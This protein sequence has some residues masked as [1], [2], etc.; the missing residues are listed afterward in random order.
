MTIEVNYLGIQWT[1][2]DHLQ[3]EG[4]LHL[5]EA[6]IRKGRAIPVWSLSNTMHLELLNGHINWAT[7]IT[8]GK[9]S[10]IILG[11]EANNS[12]HQKWLIYTWGISGISK[13][14]NLL[15]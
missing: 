10:V 7:L 12:L 5:T 6:S 3:I 15:I 13:E 11:S 14:Q 4:H 9:A 1:M 2:P 8:L